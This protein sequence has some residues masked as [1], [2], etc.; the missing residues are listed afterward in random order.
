MNIEATALSDL[1]KAPAEPFPG[2]RPFEFEESQL[3][4]GRDGQVGKL[5]EK[6]QVSRFLAVTGTSG[7]GK[8]SLVRAGLFPALL[9]GLMKEAGS[10]WRI[11]LMRPGNDPIGNLAQVLND[12]R[13]FG[14]DDPQNLSIQIAV[15]QATLRLGRR[16]LVEVVRQNALPENENLLV[17]VDQFEELFRFAREAGRKTKEESDNYQNDAAAFVKLLLEAKAQREANI[18]VVLTMRSDFLGDCA[19]FWD[20]PE[21][22]NESQYLIPRLTRE[23]LRES[24]VGPI[25][26]VGAEI[27]GRLVTQL[28]NDM[29]AGQDQL[30]VLQHLLMRIWNEAR[31]KQLS[32]EV[33]TTSENESRLHREVHSGN[34]IDLCCYESVGGMNEALS[35]HAD[36]A[37]NELPDNRHREVAERMFKALTEKGADNRE[38]RRPIVLSELCVVTGAAEPEV[39]NVIEIFRKPGRSFLMPP[40]PNKLDANS[41]IDISHESLIRKWSRLKEWVEEESRDARIYRRLAETAILHKEGGAGLWRNPDLNIALTWRKK[42]RPNEHWARRY[43]PDFDS[44]MSFLER[45]KRRFRFR[46]AAFGLLI[47]A[48]TGMLVTFSIVQARNSG[49]QQKTAEANAAALE[50]QR[51]AIIAHGERIVAEEAKKTAERERTAA[52]TQR[53]LA[54]K[55]GDLLKDQL[56]KNEAALADARAQRAKAELAVAQERKARDAA[57]LAYEAASKATQ[58]TTEVARSLLTLS[59]SALLEGLRPEARALAVQLIDKA[60][61]K[62]ITLRLF[63]GYRSIEVQNALY[64][65]GRTTPGRMVTGARFT[66]HNTGLAF[67]VAVVR[68]GKIVF[69]GPEFDVV[70]QIGEELGLVW[71]GNWPGLKDKPHFQTRNAVEELKKLRESRSQ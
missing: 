22:V 24:I 66:T 31:E 51:Q 71:G 52:D 1:I 57:K 40:V 4:F 53:Q 11:A 48:L 19:A 37:F 26:L 28:L 16:G 10:R 27:T 5:I 38:I 14:S 47:L 44:A 25:S 54:L 50:A 69:T 30:P 70:G 7:S 20:L 67:D 33:P 58:Q 61:E 59:P 8:S 42:N 29:E 68:D 17:V 12:P 43:H 23:Q 32:V 49:L 6:L 55:N 13:V 18:Y 60:K 35:R 63:G 36:E 56:K 15:A 34:A 65:Q 21:A 62:G 2:L 46:I 9:S 64:A 3:F 39:V 41:L 45:S